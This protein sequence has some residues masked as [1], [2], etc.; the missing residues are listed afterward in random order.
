MGQFFPPACNSGTVQ[1]NAS[2]LFGQPRTAPQVTQRCPLTS[3]QRFVCIARQHRNRRPWIS[4]RPEA[5][6][7]VELRTQSHR[8]VWPPLPPYNVPFRALAAARRRRSNAWPHFL[9]H[10]NHYDDES[11]EA[12]L[13]GSRPAW[14]Q[15]LASMVAIESARFQPRRAF[16]QHRRTPLGPAKRFAAH[17]SG[18][19]A[20]T[21]CRTVSIYR[22]GCYT[23]PRWR[24]KPI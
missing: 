15:R 21:R 14:S 1:Q 3:R 16:A 10:G 22:R 20:T 19:D 11:D 6:L 2:G 17:V 7:F 12:G 8:F 18:M 23:D 13:R 5:L 9:F 24:S 4:H